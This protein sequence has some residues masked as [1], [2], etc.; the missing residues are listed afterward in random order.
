M[1]SDT[2]GE[3]DPRTQNNIAYTEIATTGMRFALAA[4]T[5]RAGEIAAK[6][7]RGETLDIATSNPRAAKRCVG[8]LG[9]SPLRI[10]TTMGGAVETAPYLMPDI[11]GIF[12]LAVSGKTIAANGL[13]IVA[14]N[15]LSVSLGAVWQTTP[16][17]N[18][19]ARVFDAE[20]IIE[21]I[22]TIETRVDEAAGGARESYTQRLAADR[23]KLIQ[24]LMAECGELVLALLTGSSQEVT[25]ETADVL[26]ALGIINRVR[27]T[28]L[29]ESLGMLAA[30]NLQQSGTRVK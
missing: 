15:L 12:D 26:Y 25:S 1:G 6:I 28:S 30:R 11:D 5:E 13:K 19:P 9:G 22:A 16:T 17:A 18:A 2:Y 24:K 20:T 7:Q 27:Q 10:V 29:R 3:L 4:R 23:N 8:A 14:D 21:A